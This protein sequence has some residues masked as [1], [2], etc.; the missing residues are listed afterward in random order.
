MREFLFYKES[1]SRW[2]V[3]LPEWTESKDELEMIMGADTM[4]NIIAQGKDKVFL[5][6]SLEPFDDCDILEKIED[7]PGVGGALY[8]MKSYKGFEYNL[9]LWLCEVTRFVFGYLPERIY[10]K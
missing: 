9:R 3:D 4:L 10:I 5:N 8:L 6:I 7:T 2:Y 1:S